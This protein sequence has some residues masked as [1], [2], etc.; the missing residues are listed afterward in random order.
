[1]PK[2]DPASLF[3]QSATCP[4]G[5]GVD[6]GGEERLRLLDDHLSDREFFVGESYSVAGIGFYGDVRVADEPGSTCGPSRTWV[7]GASGCDGSLTT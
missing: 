1:L 6:E 7:R 2:P 5:R 3:Q 4:F